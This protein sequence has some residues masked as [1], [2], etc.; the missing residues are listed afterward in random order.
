MLAARSTLAL[1]PTCRALVRASQLPRAA[2]SR[3]Q[4]R[5]PLSP[6]VP[7]TTSLPSLGTHSGA[8]PTAT[9]GSLLQATPQTLQTAHTRTSTAASTFA[10]RTGMPQRGARSLGRRPTH[11]TMSRF[12]FKTQPTLPAK[13]CPTP[14]PRT[15]PTSR[16]FP[17]RWIRELSSNLPLLT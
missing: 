5:W 17:V 2:G 11:G 12:K 1:S 9:A 13:P 4:R 10:G 6:T 16:L 14:K 3:T 8:R 15:M 7:S